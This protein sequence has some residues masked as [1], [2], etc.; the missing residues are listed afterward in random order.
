TPRRW[1]SPTPRRR[2][3]RPR[4]STIDAHTLHRP[5]EQGVSGRGVIALGRA[6]ASLALVAVGALGLAGCGIQIPTDPDGSFA[7]IQGDVL[8][9]GASPETGLVVVEGAEV[10]GPLA[11]LVTAFA[12]EIDA[13]VDWTVGS[14][15]SLVTGLEEGDL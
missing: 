6:L 12:D 15:E 11:D 7:R 3:S 1:A 2:S 10:S 4:S 14:E 8:R 5:A 13:T 9:A